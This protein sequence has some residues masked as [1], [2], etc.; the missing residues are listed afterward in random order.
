VFA[1]ALI[2]A[3]TATEQGLAPFYRDHI[4]RVLADP[5]SDFVAEVLEDYEVTDA[6]YREARQ[7]FQECVEDAAPGLDVILPST[8]GI[9]VGRGDAFNERFDSDDAAQLAVDDIV[10]TCG[11]ETAN[12]IEL[13]YLGVRDNP[14]ALRYPEAL[15]EC[16]K[17]VGATDGEGLSDAELVELVLDES[18]VP[19]SD[20]AAACIADPIAQLRSLTD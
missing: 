20:A 1:L 8:G 18:Y 10:A 12:D 2:T 13:I 6:E 9:D 17:H 7:R 16:L 4:D 14:D 15:K 5:P 3:C 19:S 11:S